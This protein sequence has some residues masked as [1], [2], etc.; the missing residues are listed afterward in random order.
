MARSL[1][2]RLP[3][4]RL[5]RWPPSAVVFT[6]CVG[7]VAIHAADS[8]I[9][10]WG[11]PALLAAAAAM[12]VVAA[13]AVSVHAFRLSGAAGRAVLALVVGIGATAEAMGIS[14]AHV[15][16]GTI[17]AADYSGLLS[18][19]AGLALLALGACTI[20]VRTHGWRRAFVLPPLLVAMLY[21]VAA[22]AAAVMIAHPART[23]LTG[24]TPAQARIAYRDVTFSTLDGVNL[25]GWYIPSRNGAAVLAMA[26]A[27]G[28][29]EGVLD[30][31]IVLAR[32][33]YG[34]LAIDH[35]GHGLSGGSAMDLGWFGHLDVSGA[36]SFLFR[37]PDVDPHRIGALGLSMGAEEALTAAASDPRIAA[38]VA[39]GGFYRVFED[40]TGAAAQPLQ[41]ALLPFYWLNER[42]LQLMTPVGPP[43]PLADLVP[44]I[45]PRP[46]LLVA[47]SVEPEATLIGHLQSVAPSTTQLWAPA[48]TEHTQALSTH[49]GDWAAHVLAFL[50]RALLA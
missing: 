11:Q 43:A 41:A 20:L 6:A 10:R 42:A 48:G 21:L 33:G 38:V 34:V 45:A 7:V 15:F 23:P 17:G 3:A 47:A 46:V 13:A 24:P 4:R 40:S 26:G 22:L 25:A 19:L 1:S 12:L 16:R 44:R 28:T 31:A 30:H 2:L 49:P 5:R 50:D 9:E 36:M 18:L 39:E 27:G 37:Q 29:R 32:H 14:G 8:I 35:R